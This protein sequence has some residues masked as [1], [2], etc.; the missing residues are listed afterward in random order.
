MLIGYCFVGSFNDYRMKYLIGFDIY[1]F[2]RE[3][4]CRN[5]DD[6]SENDAVDISMTNYSEIYLLFA[7]VLYY[8]RHIF[9]HDF[10]EK[11]RRIT[12]IQE[13]ATKDMDIYGVMK[14]LASFRDCLREKR[15]V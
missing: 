6:K 5:N 12:F 15:K 14:K 8:P 9:R 13:R 3:Q 4:K 1:L 2:Q 10:N 11:F 7:W